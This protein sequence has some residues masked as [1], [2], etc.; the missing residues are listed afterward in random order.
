MS[1]RLL[2]G[3]LTVHRT[4]TDEDRHLLCEATMIS[5]DDRKELCRSHTAVGGWKSDSNQILMT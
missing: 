1:R 4:K 5:M 3:R 2:K